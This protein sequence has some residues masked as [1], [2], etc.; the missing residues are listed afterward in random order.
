MA[1]VGGGVFGGTGCEVLVAIKLGDLEANIMVETQLREAR[2]FISLTL[3]MVASPK[4]GK[5]TAVGNMELYKY[6]PFDRDTACRQNY[7]SKYDCCVTQP[8][9]YTNT[10]TRTQTRRCHYVMCVFDT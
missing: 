1:Y 5:P 6:G 2:S 7:K 9:M 10:H 8:A 4:V 3:R